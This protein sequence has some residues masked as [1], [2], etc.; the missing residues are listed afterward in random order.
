LGGEADPFGKVEGAAVSY[1]DLSRAEL[2]GELRSLANFG[3]QEVGSP[4]AHF[5]AKLSEICFEGIEP[6]PEGLAG[7][8]QPGLRVRLNV[9]A[10][11]GLTMDGE[12]PWRGD[13][14]KGVEVLGS[15]QVAS[16]LS[17]EAMSF[18]GP[19]EPPGFRERRR[20]A[21]EAPVGEIQDQDDALPFSFPG[22]FFEKRVDLAGGVVGNAEE[23]KGSPFELGEKLLPWVSDAQGE[24][25]WLG[26]SAILGEGGFHKEHGSF[27]IGP[28]GEAGDQLAAASSHGDLLGLDI[29]KLSERS[30]ELPIMR[31][32][33]MSR[34]CLADGF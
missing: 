3:E 8:G 14:A 31:V 26:S 21:G 24:F 16:P 20:I 9:L 23:G 7:L 11:K 13:A 28:M 32:G 17:G 27:E 5:E 18:I 25:G 10:Q 1:P 6:V 19:K 15:D 29:V 33:I 12:D 4:L 2:K 30:I 34:I 22:S